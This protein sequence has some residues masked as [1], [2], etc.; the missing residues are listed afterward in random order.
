VKKIN[1]DEWAEII[2]DRLAAQPELAAVTVQAMQ[3]GILTAN[4]RLRERVAEVSMGLVEAIRTK[5]GQVRR[6][7]DVIV[8]AIMASTVY[9][10]KWSDEAIAK[11][12]GH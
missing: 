1:E 9:G 8:R 2:H 10:S 11:E 6:K 7:R 12:G 5:P 4:D 3:E